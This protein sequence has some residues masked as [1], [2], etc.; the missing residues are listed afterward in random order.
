MAYKNFKSSKGIELDYTYPYSV[1]Q[2][3]IR[4]NSSTEIDSNDTTTFN[5]IEYAVAISQGSK[6]R[7]S[8]IIYQTNGTDVDMTEYGIIETGGTI[9]GLSIT[10]SISGQDAKLNI[11]ITDAATTMAVVKLNKNL[12][13]IKVPLIEGGTLAS[14]ST[15][16]YRTF[17]SSGTLLVKNTDLACDILMVA[18]GG[19]GA[20]NGGGGG[21]GGLL[22]LSSQSLAEASYPVV[23]GAGGIMV[24]DLPSNGS[25]STFNGYS[26]I[27]GGHGGTGAFNE[28]YNGGYANSGGSG[29]GAGMYRSYPGGLGTSGQGYAGGYGLNGYKFA[30]GGGGA[31]QAGGN[32]NDSYPRYCKGGNGLNTYSDWATATSTGDNGYYAGGGSGSRGDDNFESGGLGGGGKGA[33]ANDYYKPSA[34]LANTGGGGG[35]GYLGSAGGSGII[36]VRY[37]KTAV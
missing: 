8:K 15:Y 25:N 3:I 2:K 1:V 32:V 16:Y 35:G 11:T 18:G 33:G 10:G 31:G 20:S 27:G 26:A 14:D 4:S 36:I 7:S 34:G 37:L 9:S 22:Y 24:N 13:F 6:T 28:N 12:N 29:G 30:G 19:A 17:T 21:A 23:V 5:A